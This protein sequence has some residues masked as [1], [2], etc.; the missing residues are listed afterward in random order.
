MSS[1]QNSTPPST[2]DDPALR[3]EIDAVLTRVEEAR[4]VGRPSI[5]RTSVAEAAD[6]APCSWWA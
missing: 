5:A 2:P 6:R 4:L 3:A 1:H